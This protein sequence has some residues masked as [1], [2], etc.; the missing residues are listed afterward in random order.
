MGF[1]TAGINLYY[2]GGL[3]LFLLYSLELQGQT[4]TPQEEYLKLLQQT[5]DN[6]R[7]EN[8]RLMKLIPDSI[9]Y[10]VAPPH[11]PLTFR[12]NNITWNEEGKQVSMYQVITELP[13]EEVQH[14]VTKFLQSMGHAVAFGDTVETSPLILPELHPVKLKASWLVEDYEPGFSMLKVWFRMPDG[15]YLNPENYPGYHQSI[16]GIL[17]QLFHG[18]K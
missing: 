8:A 4:L 7:K 17:K 2:I 14:R 12:A 13:V 18:S 15:T 6:C 10:A 3:L 9:R 1:R 5:L 16:E 11:R